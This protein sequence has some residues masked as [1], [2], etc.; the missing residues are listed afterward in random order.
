[1]AKYKLERL[2]SNTPKQKKYTLKRK[3]YGLGDAAGNAL[4]TTVN[5]GL[6]VAK[7]VTGAAV[8]GAGKA[9]NLAGDVA[10]GVVSG[11]GKVLKAAALPL[12]FLGPAGLIG[13]AA[14]GL[15]GAAVDGVGN[16]TK[17]AVHTVGDA[18]INA[19]QDIQ[20]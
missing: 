13:G 14:L 12:A 8:E 15:T 20:V 2:F 3:M 9:T 16:L 18:A 1:M 6:G 4:T 5:T 19:G 17:K 10:G 7:N 11:T